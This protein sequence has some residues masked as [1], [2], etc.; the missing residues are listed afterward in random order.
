MLKRAVL[1]GLIATAALGLAPTAQ[2]A[3]PTRIVDRTIDVICT[4]V[5][6]DVEI[7]VAAA[8]S[9]LAGTD[10]AVQLSYASTGE[11]I[12]GFVNGDSDWGDGTFKALIPVLDLNDRQIGEVYFA[13]RYSP[14]G[15]PVQTQDKFNVGNV[16]VVEEHS[17]TPLAISGVVPKYGDLTF[18]DPTCEGSMI[19]GSLFFTNPA[20]VV[21]FG[22]DLLYFPDQ[23]T[24]DNIDSWTIEGPLMS[25][26]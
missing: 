16:H 9:D 7:T 6:E 4:A 2:A 18:D 25:C 14:A 5:S 22:S 10:S 8:R 1:I 19:E 12:G 20:T 23:C 17:E 15:G 26:S 13:G 11:T 3:A 24:L 21:Q